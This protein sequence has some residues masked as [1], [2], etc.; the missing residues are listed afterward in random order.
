MYAHRTVEKIVPAALPHP[1]LEQLAVWPVACKVGESPIWHRGEKALYWIDVRAPQL[2]RLD[3]QTGELARWQL[4]EVVGALAL[5]GKSRAWLALQRRLVQIDL[6]TG[7][8]DEVAVVE[9]IDGNRLN[10][11]KVSPSGRWFVFGS[12]DDGVDKRAAGA[13]YRANADGVVDQLHTG[14]V[15]ANGI[16][17]SRDVAT[18]YFSDSARGQLY[19]APWDEAS[20]AMG[21]PRI[22]AM[23]DEQLGRPDGGLVDSRDVYWSAGVS[24]GV[25]NRINA[26]GRLVERIRMPCL[27]PTMC[28]FGGA[29]LQSMFVTSL[30]RPQW[31]SPGTMEGALFQFRS[32]VPGVWPAHLGSQPDKQQFS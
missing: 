20:G 15:V 23:L 17:W 32:P 8:L 18:I 1:S 7:E 30:V 24:A 2:L 22:F 13:L 11:G 25:L 12:M 26:A 27:A 29:D 3:P 21:R 16:A 31:T 4:P 19:A 5:C 10:D 9:H 14:L 6:L 28:A